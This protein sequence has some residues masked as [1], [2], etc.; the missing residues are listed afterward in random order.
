MGYEDDDRIDDGPTARHTGP[1]R[2]DDDPGPCDHRWHGRPGRRRRGRRPRRDRRPPA[3]HL[4]DRRHGDVH[5]PAR[6]PRGDLGAAVHPAVPARGPVRPAVDDL[7]LH[8]HLRGLPAERRDARRP[9]RPQTAVRHR[10]RRVHARLGRLRAGPGHRR[11]D[12]LP[13]PAGPRRRDH[14]AAH[15]DPAVRRRPPGT[16]G[17]GHRRLGRAGRR[18]RRRRTGHRRRHHRGRLL[19]VDLLD[20]RP[21]R[22]AAAAAL[23]HVA[24]RVARPGPP[25]RPARQRPRQRRPVRRSSTD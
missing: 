15:P 20:Q 9:L 25:A 12:R 5:G 19:A 6:Q 10:P 23:P 18:R 22:R 7:R 2:R 3:A 4:R 8:P 17:P 13:R 21:A 14:G 1:G 11:A 16:P 24:D